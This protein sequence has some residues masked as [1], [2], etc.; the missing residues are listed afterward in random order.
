MTMPSA[1][2]WPY[3]GLGVDPGSD[4]VGCRGIRIGE[5]GRCLTHADEVVRTAY[6]SALRPGSHIILPGTTLTKELLNRILGALS[7]GESSRFGYANLCEAIID[8]SAD[9]IGATFEGEANFIGTKFRQFV[10]FSFAEFQAE[11]EFALAE[12]YQNTAFEE[13]T[14]AERAAFNG[15]TFA[16]DASFRD[17]QFA[18]GIELE[19]VTFDD[20]VTFEGTH[21]GPTATIGP[22]V[23][24][25]TVNLS[26]ST[27]AAPTVA[28]IAATRILCNRTRWEAT[29][30]LRLRYATMDLTDAVIVQPLA[31]TSYPSPFSS[32]NWPVDESTLSTGTPG[33]RLSSIR[34]VDCA[35]VTLTDMNLTECKFS[36]AFHLDQLRFEGKWEFATPPR[37]TWGSGIAFRWTQRQVIAEERQWRALPSRPRTLRAGWGEPPQDHHQVPGLATLTTTYRQL[38]KAREDAKDEPGA[39]DFY[40]GE[41]EMRR[42]SNGWCRA[43]RWLLQAYWLLSGYG[44]RASRALIWLAL[45][46]MSTI[47]LMAGYGLPDEPPKQEITREKIDSEWRTVIDKPDPENPTGDR[48]TSKRFEKALNVT[49]NSV[50]FRSSG[51]DLTTA[52]TYIEMASRLSEPVLLGLAVLAIRGR[53]KRGS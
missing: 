39:A 13:G 14:F 16:R 32:L 7:E 29:A 44:L 1:P 22:L 43:E 34:G 50:V 33:A 26:T 3:C 31:I 12:F 10:D 25:G 20:D 9:F 40:Y 6:L 24:A 4:R 45:A 19:S 8:G 38:R 36:Q 52:G 11:A 2:D 18:T 49:L 53:V 47:L 28:E 42:H 23:C 15:A 30:A 35:M 17:C 48:F 41:M 21:F 46:M 37:S 5:S 51:Q 27:F